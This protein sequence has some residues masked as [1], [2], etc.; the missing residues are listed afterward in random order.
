[1]VP[2]PWVSVEDTPGGTQRPHGSPRPPRTRVPALHAERAEDVEA[3]GALGAAV[4]VL[5]AD[6]RAAG[7]VGGVCAGKA[8]F[9]E[10]RAGEMGQGKRQKA[11][12]AHMQG[13]GVAQRSSPQ[14]LRTP[15]NLAWCRAC[16]ATS[17]APTARSRPAAAR[18]AARP[19]AAARRTAGRGTCREGAGGRA[20]G[21]AVLARSWA[22]ARHARVHT[23]SRG[24]SIHPSQQPAAVSN[25]LEPLQR[26]LG[27]VDAGLLHHALAAPRVAAV[28][29][30]EGGA[31]LLAQAHAARVHALLE[32]MLLS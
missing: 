14:K 5:E 28:E 26:A 1:M 13:T 31:A 2:R 30:D 22:Q 19:A 21:R 15:T 17:A 9:R 25:A 7:A 29:A 6:R 24:S 12:Q 3:A 10:G 32:R 8:S 16:A 4:V 27:H 18:A 20:G 11:E 23:S